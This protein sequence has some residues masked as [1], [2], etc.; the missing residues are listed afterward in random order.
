MIQICI[1]Y[2][3]SIQRTEILVAILQPDPLLFRLDLIFFFT[4]FL[5]EFL[6]MYKLF[7][8]H[9]LDFD[10]ELSLLYM[11]YIFIYLNYVLRPQLYSL[12]NLEYYLTLINS[13]SVSYIVLQQFQ[14]FMSFIFMESFNSAIY[15]YSLSLHMACSCILDLSL[16]KSLASAYLIID[17]LP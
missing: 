1:N 2:K 12:K 15:D 10:R 11:F 14:I 4:V 5:P 17:V 8:F 13:L 9:R 16:L 6:G 3:T 7:S